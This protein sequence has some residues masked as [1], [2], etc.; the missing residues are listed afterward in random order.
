M[1]LGFR[2]Q[3]AG[4][5]VWG[6]RPHPT[7]NDPGITAMMM[8]MMM[9]IVNQHSAD[10]GVHSNPFVHSRVPQSTRGGWDEVSAE[11]KGN[12]VSSVYGGQEAIGILGAGLLALDQGSFGSGFIQ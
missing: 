8:M 11:P 6:H 10:R 12:W 9:M 5:E 1:R 2:V 7:S 4:S 3:G